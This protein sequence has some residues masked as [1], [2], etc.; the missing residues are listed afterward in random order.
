MEMMKETELSEVDND[1]LKKEFV[2]FSSIRRK[3]SNVDAR[4][5][6]IHEI[7]KIFHESDAH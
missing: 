6:Y 4:D 3:G 7:E 2:Y 1:T 5:L